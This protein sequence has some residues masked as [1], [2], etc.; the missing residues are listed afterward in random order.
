M[1]EKKRGRGR[2]RKHPKVEKN[3]K[4]LSVRV[5]PDVHKALKDISNDR[6]ISVSDCLRD[7]VTM[8]DKNKKCLFCNKDFLDIS[9]NHNRNYCCE[10][11][12]YLANLIRKKKLRRA[13]TL[14]KNFIS[15]IKLFFAILGFTVTV[16]FLLRF[17]LMALKCK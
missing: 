10:E 7:A 13:N 11:H 4:I 3:T 8:V 2:P 9:R 17:I 12:Y 16:L 15:K 6:N 5:A 14:S 1:E